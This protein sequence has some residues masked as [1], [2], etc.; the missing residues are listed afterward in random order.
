MM[1]VD[2][3]KDDVDYS[4][5]DDGWDRKMKR[6]GVKSF[7]DDVETKRVTPII[8]DYTAIC[9]ANKARKA[10]LKNK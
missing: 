1:K 8:N 6:P 10:K 3:K 7:Y 9:A 2:N 5:L 4:H